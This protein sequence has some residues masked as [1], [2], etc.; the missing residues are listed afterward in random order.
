MIVNSVNSVIP[1]GMVYEPSTT[2]RYL[3]KQMPDTFERTTSPIETHNN[4][5][6][7]INPKY[8]AVL[9]TLELMN[10]KAQ[11]AFDK[12]KN[13]DGWS[14]KVVDKISSLWGSKNRY[15][16]VTE[17]L[18]M[19]KRQVEKLENAARIGNFKAEYFNTFGVNYDEQAVKDFEAVSAKYTA[20][21]S[22]EQISAYMKENLTEYQKFFT[23]HKNSIN[24]ESPDFESCGKHVNIDKK[25]D[26]Y[27][28]ELEK[29]VG[30]K[31]NLR[32][33]EYSQRRDFIILS[34]EEQI[35]VLN[36]ISDTLI[37]TT[38]ATADKLKDG[39]SD[40][41]IQK[42]YD[43][44][45]KKAFG[46]KNNIQKRVDKYV[47]SQQIRS[48]ALKD[49]IVAGAIGATIAL[50]QTPAPIMTGAAVTTAGYIGLD[51]SDLA[52]NNIDNKEDLNEASVK[53]V[54]K[55]AAI[56]GL[57][58]IV[59]SKMYDII[60]EPQVKNK[61]L[62]SAL[63]TVRTL[64]IEIPV[65]FVSEYAQTGKWATYQMNPKDFLKIALSTFAIEELTRM[66]ISSHV[67]Q[68]APV[69]LDDAVV[70]KVTARANRELQKQFEKNPS[71]FL[72][73]KL[74]SLESPELFGELMKS[75]LNEIVNS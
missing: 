51:L 41:E 67:G 58:Y 15:S 40:K 16:A 74:I 21:K 73:L 69:T 35:A 56:C 47:Q 22:A 12:Q 71:N 6:L 52:T 53:D 62:K 25:L 2:G 7:P 36:D 68:K 38:K 5:T 27:K 42:E 64:G 43:E 46:E 34:K 3:K 30:G 1:T 32:R 55:C 4:S 18:Q 20:I 57:E 44:A 37:Y 17:D 33:L 39:K 48:V 26:S 75:T 19:H 65:A 11:N 10:I 49:F 8:T 28:K 60:P 29:M 70:E 23:K 66:G 13:Y 63:N 14:G 61:V 59:G 31:E 24:P 50:T 72:N 45:Y 54:V 9:D